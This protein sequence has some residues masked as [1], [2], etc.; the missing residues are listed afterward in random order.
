MMDEK[1]EFEVGH[2]HENMKGIYEVISIND[3]SMIIRWENGEQISTSTDLQRRIIERIQRQERDNEK[4]Q[5]Q[6]K[7]P[8]RK[9]RKS[10][11]KYGSQFKGFEESDFKKNVTETNWRSRSRL[12]GAV[13]ERLP[14]D[15]FNFNSWAAYRM[16]A[17][18]WADVKHRGRDDILL[19]AKF[20]AQ[21][22]ENY[23]YYGFYIERSDNP[24]DVKNDWNTFISWLKDA[25]N[26][27]W[28]NEIVSK[29]NLDIYDLDEKSFSGI[30]KSLNKKWE[31]HSEEILSLSNL[32]DELPK[33]CCVDLHIAKK[34]DRDKAL[35]KG[36]KIADDIST[37]FE[38][39]MPLYEASTAHSK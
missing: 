39:L 28:L 13:T 31:I 24:T 4:M 10:T 17:I 3:D 15:K 27:Y 22:D 1:I 5:N 8:K 16:P 14:S 36:E 35:S 2:K 34:V 33:K 6:P 21:V 30:I 23:L 9:N 11:S 19:Q 26:E 18:H 29:H 32:L 20:F 38:A 7:E 12:G 25:K 37:L